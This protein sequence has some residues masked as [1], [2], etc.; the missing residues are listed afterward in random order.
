MSRFLFFS[1]NG[2]EPAFWS[3]GRKM[4]ADFASS[5]HLWGGRHSRSVECKA[6]EFVRRMEVFVQEAHD[7]LYTRYV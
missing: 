4:L 7:D 2:I 3:L 1:A 6:V 5:V